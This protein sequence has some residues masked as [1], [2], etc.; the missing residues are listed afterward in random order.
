MDRL[1]QLNIA[2]TNLLRVI[3]SQIQVKVNDKLPALPFNQKPT[4]SFIEQT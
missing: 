2:P 3:P 1:E 4:F